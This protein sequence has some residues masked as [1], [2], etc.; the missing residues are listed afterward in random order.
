MSPVTAA[1][2]G[3]KG[4]KVLAE[5]FIEPSGF[6]FQTPVYLVKH[7]LTQQKIYISTGDIKR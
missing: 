5:D 4:T 2:I 6:V 1:F 3:L 7:E